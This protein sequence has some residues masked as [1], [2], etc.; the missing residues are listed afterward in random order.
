MLAAPMMGSLA[1]LW[2]AV[3]V[4]TI[5][6]ALLVAIEVHRGAAEAAWKYVLIAS[7]GLGLALLATVF[8]YFAGAQVLGEHYNLA[9]APLIA[10][11]AHLP[12]TPVRLAFMLAVLGYGTKVGLFPVHTWLPDAHSEAPTPVSALLSGSLLAISFYAILRFYQVASANLGSGFPRDTLL[13]FGV[14]SLLLAALYVFGQ[15]DIKRLLAYS[16]V[17]HMGILAIGVSFGA[18]VALAGVMLHV[19]AHAAAKGN[20]FMGAGVFTVKFGTKQISALRGGLDVLPWSGPLFLL[21]VFALSAMPPSGIFRSEF[22]IVYGGLG[23][24]QLRGRRGPGRAGHDGVLRP[25][26]LRPPGCCS[27]PAPSPRALARSEPAPG[28]WSRSWRASRSCSSSACTRPGELTG[29]I[30]RAVTQLGV[31][32]MTMTSRAGRDGAVERTRVQGR[33]RGQVRRPVRDRP[34]PGTGDAPLVLSA[35]VA[36]EGGIDTL[37]APLPPGATSYPALTP[38]LGAAFWYEREIHDHFGVVPE[39]H[40]RLAPLIRPGSDPLP[41]HVTGYGLFT[42]PHGPVRSGVMESIEYLVETPGEAIPHL[43]M[44]VFY[45][46]RGVENR[47]AG[48]TPAD[49]VLLAERTEGIA[50]VAHALAFSHAIERIA[51]CGRQDRGPGAG[52]ARR[53]RADREPPRRRGQAGRRGRA[54]RGHG[55]ARAAQGAGAAAGQQAVRQP[56]R[57]R[58]GGPRR[59]QRAAAAAAAPRCG[60]EIGRLEKSVTAEAAALMATSSFLD[61]LRGTGP[62]TPER[63]RA[64]GALGPIGKAAGFADDARLARPYDGYPSLAVA[65][66]PRARRRRRAGPAAGPLGGGRTSLSACSGRPPKIFRPNGPPIRPGSPASLPGAR[67]GLGRGPPGRGHLRRER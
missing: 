7:A 66:R 67:R 14:A 1:L 29:L 45:K 15:R 55:P 41:R 57:P 24:R 52:A 49:G 30:S 56:V 26:R 25:D 42:I 31:G 16:S 19:L 34:R 44:R 43:N 63:A 27:P 61:R 23:S 28:W 10:A 17:E 53:T 54:R 11:G 38:R 22:Q 36:T 18:P 46:H 5:V 65:A 13:A 60:A 20:A 33:R 32:A 35:H 64:H 51:G 47:F 2:I 4:T 59:G 62:L 21:A 48:M 6:S 40:P 50:S 9:I 37:E 8:A 3:E 39:G 12:H 58:R